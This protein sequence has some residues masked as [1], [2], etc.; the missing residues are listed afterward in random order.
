MPF[1]K[2]QYPA[3][4]NNYS[5]YEY[6]CN[7]QAQKIQTSIST[8]RTFS[9]LYTYDSKGRPDEYTYPSGLT[10]K[11]EYNATN[12][13]LK[14]VIDKST[15][16]AIYEPGTYNA[17]GQMLHY[18]MNNK[19]LYT[20]LGYNDF[21]LPTYRMTG[22]FYP[23]AND[24]QYLETNFNNQTGNLNWR[25]DHSRSLTENFTY[26]AVHKNRLAT[27]QVQGQ[28]Q[29]GITYN[30][31]N[32]NIITKTDFTSPGNPYT[33][34]LNAGPH[35]VTGVNAPLLM[36][37]E[38]Q[39]EISY[40]SFNKASYINH[41]YQRREL[42]LHYG[43]DEQRI[44]T[45]Y[46]INGQTTLTR[47]FPGGGLE[48]EVDANGQ[49]RWL[50][51]LPGGG[52]YVCDK[53]FNKTGMYYVLTDYLGSWHKVISETGTTIEEYSFDP[54][55]RRRN[56]AN[57]TYTGVPASFTFNR[58]YT[59][60]EMLDAFNL[61]NMNGRMYDPVMGRM[62]SPD[63]YVSS[64]SSTQAFNRYSYALNNPLVITDPTGDHPAI[65]AAIAYSAI[66]SGLMSAQNGDGFMQGFSTG[67]AT[68]MVSFGVGAAIGPVMQGVGALPGLVNAGINSSVAG[69]ITY[70]LDAIVNN[71][72]F[73]WK[74]WAINVGTA[75]AFGA[76]DGG[77]EAYSED[78]LNVWTGKPINVGRTKFSLI[79]NKPVNQSDLYYLDKEGN[80]IHITQY[81]NQLARELAPE[82]YRDVY[83]RKG[84]IVDQFTFDLDLELNSLPGEEV[85]IKIPQGI[86]PKGAIG[87][88]TGQYYWLEDME[89]KF[90]TS[91]G[92]SKVVTEGPS[93]FTLPSK[94][95]K[96]ITAEINGTGINDGAINSPNSF[97]VIVRRHR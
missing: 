57:W 17:R 79:N 38:A 18:A 20:T 23:T 29:Y 36:P 14:K 19:S 93:N 68:G 63:N 72:P 94:N 11:N 55:G 85:T 52:L 13:T 69:F 42:F 91:T 90:T 9:Y 7:H 37:A 35:A 49:E 4:S 15:N 46:K 30:H 26:D 84:G 67:M 53:N 31:A 96:F 34:G 47:Y 71:S 44:K 10:I 1:L 77:F 86:K 82:L 16:T 5:T 39:Q 78:N 45:E 50:H 73:N 40:N 74:G 56:P 76:V 88:E 59:G 22:K 61:I 95:V 12:G 83:Y 41:N 64:A 92:Y 58:G 70:G 97:R 24:I 75:M 62:L 51:Y 27:W 43:P 89:V 32:G 65:I 80:A 48:V 8:N 87:I 6:T 66:M 33:Y 21:G 3:K 2:S 25:K 28:Q 60:H 81:Y 54:W